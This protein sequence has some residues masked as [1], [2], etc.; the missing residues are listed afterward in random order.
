[1]VHRALVVLLLAMPAAG[2]VAQG[3]EGF[4]LDLCSAEP[5]DAATLLDDL[6]SADVVY[7][8]ET[9]SVE[10]HHVL[11]AWVVEE[12]AAR[13][14]PFFV[15]MEQA[16]WGQQAQIDRYNDGGIG[17]EELV[18]ATNW[19]G[20]WSNIRDYEPVIEAA[21]RAGAPIVGINARTELI[22]AIARGGLDELSPEQ[23]QELPGQL[24]LGDPTYRRLLKLQLPVHTGISDEV[25]EQMCD[26]QIARDASMASRIVRFMESEGGEG[27]LAVVI[28]GSGHVSFGLGTPD[29]VRSLRPDLTDRIVLFTVSGELRLSPDEAAMAR[30]VTVTHEDLR[31]VGRPVADYLHARSPV[32]P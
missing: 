28:A 23:R 4:W 8:G 32:D 30:D 19:E 11:E 3:V 17:F 20:R 31:T 9:H 16:E 2:A 29:R 7:L 13:G 21:H 12:L 5:V 6:V 14:V 25:L 27:R 22:R 24:W 15:A 1:M 18:E 26:A 10:R